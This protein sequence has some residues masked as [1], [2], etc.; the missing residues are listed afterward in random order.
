VPAGEQHVGAADERGGDQA[1]GDEVGLPDGVLVQHVAHEHHLADHEHA[2]PD[3]RRGDDAAELRDRGGC[4]ERKSPSYLTLSAFFDQLLAVGT[5]LS[6]SAY[7]LFC[8]TVTHASYSAGVR[9][10]TSTLCS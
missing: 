4:R 9:V 6:N 3:Q 5:S 7:E 8:A 2:E 1:P 10:M